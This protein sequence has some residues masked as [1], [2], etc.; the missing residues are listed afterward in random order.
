MI[1][2]CRCGNHDLPP[3]AAEISDD[4]GRHGRERIKKL[5]NKNVERDF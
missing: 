3:R 5:P 4:Q 2:T 1:P